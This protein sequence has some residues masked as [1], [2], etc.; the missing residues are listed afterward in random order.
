MIKK[1]IDGKKLLSEFKFYSGNYSKYLI[2]KN[3]YESWN[4]SVEI[5]MNMHKLKYRDKLEVLSPYLAEVEEA[6]KNKYLLGSQ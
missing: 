6:Y 4:E 3:R 1:Q 2:D 5:V